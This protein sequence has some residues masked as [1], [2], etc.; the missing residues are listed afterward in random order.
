MPP[1]PGPK[2]RRKRSASLRNSMSHHSTRLEFQALPAVAS[3]GNRADSTTFEGYLHAA[4]RAQ[5]VHGF[6]VRSSRESVR[7]M[8]DII[9]KKKGSK[10]YG[11]Y[12]RWTENGKRREKAS[13]Q[14][15]YALARRM[16]VEIEARVARGEVGIPEPEKAQLTVT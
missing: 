3:P 10:D 12:I 15:T 14:P 2:R 5:I 8:G 16:L 13:R 7:D 11:W 1:E 9:R 4:D 6:V